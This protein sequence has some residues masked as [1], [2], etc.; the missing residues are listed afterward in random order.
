M[1]GAAL[2]LPRTFLK[3]GSWNSKNFWKIY[4]G[5]YS[6]S[7]LFEQSRLSIWGPYPK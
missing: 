6:G 7:L 4:S 1:Q 5:I 2:H 3:K